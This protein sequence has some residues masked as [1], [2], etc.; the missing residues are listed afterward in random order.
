ML[1]DLRQL[2]EMF[3]RIKFEVGQPILPFQQLMSCLPPL[4]SALVPKPYRLLMTSPDS[5]ILDFYP[6]DFEVD[7]NGK[8]NPWE[9]VNLL[10]FIEIN[11]LLAAIHEHCP[12]NKL[13]PAERTRNKK[14]NIYCYTA[15]VTCNDTI[16]APH[17]GIGLSDIPNCHSRVTILPEYNSQGVTFKPELI[18]GTKIPYPGFPSLKVVPIASAELVPIRVNVF[19]MPSKY[20][21]MV[22]KLHEVPQMPS[23]EELAKLL[24]NRSLFINWPMMHEAK[25]VAVSDMATQVRLVKNKPKVNKLNSVESERWITDSTS[26]M[27][28]YFAGKSVPGSGGVQIGEVKV[29][30]KLLPLQGMRT[31]P[32]TGATKKVFGNEEADVPMQLALWQNPAPDLRFVERG[33]LSLA[34][35]FP[36][37][38]NVLLTKGKYTG[39]LGTV[40]AVAD[41]KS[42]GVKVS[43][44]PPEIPFGLAL[45]RSLFESYVS[46]GE[47]ARVLKISPSIFGR[48]A[49]S[50]IVEPGKYDLGLNLKSGDGLY[51]PGYARPKV[52]SG[53]GKKGDGEKKA[54][55]TGDSVLVVGSERAGVRSR[56][57][58]EERIFW[59]YTT[60]A[61]RL[62]NEYREKFPQL[63]AA[64]A[65]QPNEKKYDATAIFGPNG[66]EWLPTIRTW[67]NNVESAKLPRSPTS[68]ETLSKD[69][70]A[71][72]E[73][74]ANVLNLA[75][76]KKGYPKDSVVKIP[77]SALYLEN[78]TGATDVILGGDFN[79]NAAPELGDRVV[80]LCANGIP[81]GAR[82]TV[83]AIHEDTSGCVEIV[84]DEEFVGGTSLQGLCSNFRGKLCVWAHLLRITVE[85]SDSMVDKILPRG[86]GK[87]DVQ[88]ILA[89][90]EKHSNNQ[91]STDNP[92]NNNKSASRNGS[93]QRANKQGTP[94]RAPDPTSAVANV[95]TQGQSV[96]PASKTGSAPRAN[97]AVSAGKAR[98]GSAGRDK[99]AGWREASGPPSKNIGF[100]WTRKA[101]KSGLNRWK[102]MVVK[103]GKT[104]GKASSGARGTAD[105]KAMLGVTTEDVSRNTVAPKS[106]EL[107]AMLG[108]PNSSGQGVTH[109]APKT[110]ELKAMLG[111]STPVNVTA[112]VPA[113][114]ATEGLKALL[115]V[116]P[117]APIP[118]PQ[119][120]LPQPVPLPSAADKL[121]QLMSKSQAPIPPAPIPGQAAFNFTYTEE[122]K[123]PPMP[124][125]P[126]PFTPPPMAFPHPHMAFP[127]P[128]PVPMFAHG[129]VPAM[130]LPMPNAIFP[131]M[132]LNVMPQ[133]VSGPG[134]VSD[135]EFPALGAEKKE[136]PSSGPVQPKKKSSTKGMIVPSTVASRVAE[137]KS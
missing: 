128:P 102:A 5:P 122:G 20:P 31:D 2:P 80:N 23:A 48:I 42:V 9:G 75:I 34:D 56:E 103:Q 7:M 65:K 12:D 59:E 39:C 17:K 70:V 22:L 92:G 64:L 1:S 50:L 112:P 107:K 43:T 35:R 37:G 33:P 110:A 13:T 124:A 74:A 27:Q 69:A 3:S 85:N 68:T 40:V 67:L 47:A 120:P 93:S 8:K 133:V 83:V 38:S 62:V 111:V 72:V 82:G 6:T 49:G 127:P 81:F 130:N 100:A 26:M 95:P 131:A 105:L 4:S 14:G 126:M 86:S 36:V 44:M 10:P 87:A 32:K 109:V 30:L 94:K 137:A 73:K 18:P 108:V 119:P 55:N 134:I 84:L 136:K 29:R 60:K 88:K 24:L 116:G 15:D 114:S 132:P 104:K 21:T 78:S 106:A 125:P 58:S 66:V 113:G 46:S 71:A 41:N 28:G 99:Q 45:A 61:I 76:K 79:G 25:V 96:V 98:A 117:E 19:G 89:S 90:I 16:K 121:F 123:G 54:W 97:R 63:F 11:R 91:K 135:D 77:G 118:V 51:V 52:D 129:M 53:K 101:G 57:S 115:G